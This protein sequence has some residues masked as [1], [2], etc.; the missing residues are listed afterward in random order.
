MLIAVR[1]TTLPMR[2]SPPG[3]ARVDLVDKPEREEGTPICACPLPGGPLGFR[4]RAGDR[5]RAIAAECLPQI[6]CCGLLTVEAVFQISALVAE[7]LSSSSST[8]PT[9][10]LAPRTAPRGS[11]TNSLFSSFHRLL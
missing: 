3:I 8:S 6:L 7:Q 2:K 9:S 5:R 4:R 1:V 10:S 11:S